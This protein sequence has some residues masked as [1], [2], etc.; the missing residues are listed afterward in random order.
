MLTSPARLS[1][2]CR[3]GG[4]HTPRQLPAFRYRKEK[5]SE[6][7]TVCWR[8][9]DSNFRFLGLGRA[10]FTPLRSL[11]PQRAREPQP[12]FDDRQRQVYRAP[13]QAGPACRRNRRCAVPTAGSWDRP[14]P[15]STRK[16]TTPTGIPAGI[17]AAHQA[18]RERTPG[19]AALQERNEKA[20]MARQSRA[21]L[22]ARSYSARL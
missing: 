16:M 11:E 17:C 19:A 2:P 22:A 21:S 15:A 5:S 1:R 10:F 20:A 14:S 3:L 6:R 9:M 7:R 8:E 4:P 13:S 18:V 12:G